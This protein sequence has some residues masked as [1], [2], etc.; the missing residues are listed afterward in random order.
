MNTSINENKDSRIYVLSEQ[1]ICIRPCWREANFTDLDFRLS[2]LPSINL[3]LIGGITKEKGEKLS[4]TTYNRIRS[5]CAVLNAVQ[6]QTF[7]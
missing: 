2:G 4:A 5:I 3:A 7:K 1:F 6:Q